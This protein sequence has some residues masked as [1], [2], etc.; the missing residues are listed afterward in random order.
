MG[1][2]S[3]WS[4]LA[5]MTLFV[6]L[7]ATDSRK[8]LQHH[9]NLANTKVAQKD[10]SKKDE[11]RKRPRKEKKKNVV[12]QPKMVMGLRILLT[13]IDTLIWSCCTVLIV[14]MSISMVQA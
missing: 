7:V 11:N 6:V 5:V 10:D 8:L 3:T 2:A 1:Y 9:L 13:M 4:T 12:G 14:P